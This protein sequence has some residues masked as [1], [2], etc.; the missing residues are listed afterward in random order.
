MSARA[1]V[2]V[3]DNPYID[4]LSLPYTF[5]NFVGLTDY[6]YVHFLDSPYKIVNFGAYM[7]GWEGDGVSE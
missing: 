7:A 2:D 6:S 5:V 1:S 4:I 3:T